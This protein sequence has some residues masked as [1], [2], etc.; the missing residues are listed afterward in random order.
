MPPA[1]RWPSDCTQNDCEL[2][3][4]QWEM[5]AADKVRITVT[6]KQ[7]REKWV[8]IGFSET[9]TMVCPFP[10]YIKLLIHYQNSTVA[11]L[12][13][14]EWIINFTHSLKLI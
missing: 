9:P 1:A 7:A 14:W 10:V 5:V 11:Q 2:Y 12:N 3:S 8:A 13:F 6:A 4:A